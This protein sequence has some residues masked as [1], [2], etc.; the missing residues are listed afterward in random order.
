VNVQWSVC[1]ENARGELVVSLWHHHFGRARGNR[2]SCAD[3]ATRWSGPGNS[4][5]RRALDKAFK[6]GQVLRAVIART[7]DT[8]AI[9]RGDDASKIKK[10]FSV[11][12]D[13]Y[14]RVVA[15]DGEHYEIEFEDR[16]R[17]AERA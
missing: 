15:W 4:E 16:S 5:F 14:G 9:Q 12:E 7:E 10:A 2:I 3:T 13:W 17:P 11:K 1:A 6:T 8:A